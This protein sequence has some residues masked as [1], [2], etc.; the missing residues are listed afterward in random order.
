MQS[1]DGVTMPNVNFPPAGGQVDYA[2]IAA[3]W[4][5]NSNWMGL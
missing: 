4:V 2:A 3:S 5:F 1:P